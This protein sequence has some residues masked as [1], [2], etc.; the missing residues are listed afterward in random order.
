MKKRS[1]IFIGGGV[2]VGALIIIG[3][4]AGGG[5]GSVNSVHKDPPAVATAPTEDTKAPAQK[6]AVGEYADGISVS[7][8]SLTS[9]VSSGYAVP[10]NTPYASFTVTVKNGTN[11]SLDNSAIDVTCTAN[12]SPSDPVFDDGLNGTPFGH[13]LPGDS[14]SFKYGCATNGGNRV[15]VEVI[16]NIVS[17]GAD[18][19]AAVFVKNVS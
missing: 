16:P 17:F 18:G 11:K 19:N 14:I 3:A 10:A 5:S 6:L 15:Q 8:G 2:T 9:H 13:T 1:K 7:V 4:V 12:G